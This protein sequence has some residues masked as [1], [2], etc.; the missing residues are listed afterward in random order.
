MAARLEN[1]CSYHGL[2]RVH[3]DTKCGLRKP[4]E[5]GVFW[6]V[7]LFHL[8]ASVPSYQLLT[9]LFATSSQKVKK[10]K[11]KKTNLS[12]FFIEVANK[13]TLLLSQF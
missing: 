9:F 6:P 2:Q 11:K 8:P 12:S 7:S 4:G 1:S 13:H 3:S 5:A 10:M